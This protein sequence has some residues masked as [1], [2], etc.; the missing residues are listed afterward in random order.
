MLLDNYCQVLHSCYD[1]KVTFLNGPFLG[2]GGEG[3]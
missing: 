1:T 3:G 2:G